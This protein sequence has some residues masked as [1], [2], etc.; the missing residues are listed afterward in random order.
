MRFAGTACFSLTGYCYPTATLPGEVA[1][2]ETI[3][4]SPAFSIS[5]AA[6]GYN[7]TTLNSPIDI[8]EYSFRLPDNWLIENDG[9]LELDLSYT[10]NQAEPKTIQASL[11]I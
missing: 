6:L 5:L 8:T 9:R 2:P 1:T 4:S 10:Y 7:Q 11:R 3:V